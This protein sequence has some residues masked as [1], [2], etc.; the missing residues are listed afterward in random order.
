[1][2]WLLIFLLVVQ[3]AL[4][5]AYLSGE[6]A[7]VIKE[8]NLL[9][10]QPQQYVAFLETVRAQYKDRLWN[11]P[12]GAFLTKEGVAA[13]D[14]A[15]QALKATA[16]MGPLE[17]MLG[18]TLAARDHTKDQGPSGRVGHDG[19]DGSQPQDRINRYGGGMR[20]GE[21]ISYGFSAARDIVVQLLVDDGWPGR[22]HRVNLLQPA[23]EQVGVSIGSHREYGVMCVMDFAAGFTDKAGLVATPP[24]P[25][26]RA[27]SA[28]WGSGSGSAPAKPGGPFELARGVALAHYQA[29]VSDDRAAWMDTW[30]R[31]QRGALGQR[32]QA[33]RLTAAGQEYR[34]AGTQ[35]LSP[36]RM[37]LVFV[38]K[39]VRCPITLIL[40]NGGWK[41]EEASY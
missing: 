19:S 36:S 16:P 37:T 22:G 33:A 40:E 30:S 6:E 32:W 17:P 34:Y 13:V 25:V 15:I 8:I 29:L 26:P 10:T 11:R 5:Q 38:R 31:T 24:T 12:G 23:Y 35:R 39:S 2:R 9:R 3:P 20:T 21:N 7:A 28:G 18:L 41:V 1:M 14:E 27:S 4:A